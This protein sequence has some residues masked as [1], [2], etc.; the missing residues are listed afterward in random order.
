VSPVAIALLSGLGGAV[1][2]WVVCDTLP[3]AWAWLT[4]PRP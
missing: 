4:R 2:A 3:R 1:F